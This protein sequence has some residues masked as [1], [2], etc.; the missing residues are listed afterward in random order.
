MFSVKLGGNRCWVPQ[1]YA[2]FDPFFF[3]LVFIGFQCSFVLVVNFIG[4]GFPVLEGCF[5]IIL[6]LKTKQ[7]KKHVDE[8]FVK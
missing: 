5:I 2:R 4:H 3:L 6:L 8:N 7:K 1:E